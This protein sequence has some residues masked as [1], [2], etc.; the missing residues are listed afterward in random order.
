M[1]TPTKLRIRRATKAACV[2]S[3]IFAVLSSAPAAADDASARALLRTMTDYMAAQTSL[4]AQFDVD[5]DIVTPDIE[6]IQFAASGE[7]QL[8]RPD[9]L[10]ITRKG[11]YADVELLYDGRTATI[12]DR[13]GNAFAQAAST[14]SVDSLIEHLRDHYSVDMPAGDL[15][16]TTS[17]EVLLDGVI[18]AKH[19][20]I[21]VIDGVD[22]TH[23]AFRN[24]D[25]DWQIWI[26]TGDKPLPCKL[27]ITSKTVAAGPEYT[28]RFH[29]WDVSRLPPATFAFTAAPGARAAQFAD[30]AGIG[31]LP[32][33]A[34]A[35]EGGSR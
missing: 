34:P 14:G 17:Y 4:S 5:L 35:G 33:P 27:I 23:L 15:L 10:R 31:D 19:I 11:G 9:K 20:G 7:V 30:L 21:G 18:E 29:D 32:A 1:P 6:K 12:I 16:L 8:S 25:T 28:I 26:R 24:A 13:Y 3:A 22:C 2:L